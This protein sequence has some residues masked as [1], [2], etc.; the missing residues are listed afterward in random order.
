MKFVAGLSTETKAVLTTAYY[1][2]ARIDPSNTIVVC[3][4][5]PGAWAAPTPNYVTSECPL[6]N[7]AYTIGRTMF[8]TDRL[9]SGWGARINTMDEVWVPSRFHR[10]IFIEGGVKEDK[11]RVVHEPVDT[12]FYNPDSS[13]DIFPLVGRRDGDYIYLSVFKWEERKGWDVL[14]KAF[15]QEFTSAD[16]VALYLLTNSY[17][18]DSNFEEHIANTIVEGGFNKDTIP[19]I[20]IIPPGIPHQAMP[21]LYRG[22]DALVQ[23]S[24]GEGWGR[25]HAEA[26]AM[27]KPVI[28][29][30]WSGN[31][32]FMTEDNSF[33][34]NI[35]GLV[36]LTSGPF[37]GHRWAQPSVAHLRH[38]MRYLYT[39]PDEGIAKGKRA[40]EDMINLY[41]EG[42]MGEKVM[43][44]FS[45][46]VNKLHTM[47]Q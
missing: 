22:I 46:I 12:V 40:R 21:S 27:G 37:E 19:R 41:S 3:H 38:L 33:L 26:M 4:S 5:E 20:V 17:H 30:N 43:T 11:V 28:A 10:E 31:T 45:E 7:A 47:K 25:P 23:P 6:K 34:L 15:L 16:K 8:E 24:R 32:E 35:E 29:T 18:S 36:E 9:P 14:L 13:T 42:A 1:A 2:A 39:H 44:I